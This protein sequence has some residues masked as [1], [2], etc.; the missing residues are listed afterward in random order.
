M[1]SLPSAEYLRECVDYDAETGALT[2]RA[3]PPAHFANSARHKA[4]VSQYAGKPA[5]ASKDGNGYL[6]GS[7]AGV[8]GIKAH[9]VIWKLVHG[10][11]PFHIDHANGDKT[12]NR[13]CNLRNVDQSENAKNKRL[14]RNNTSGHMGVRFSRDRRW[15][16]SI[17]ID[18]RDHHLGSYATKSEAILA[19][20]AAEARLGFHPNHGRAT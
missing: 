5:F 12:D 15:L 9:R 18:R 13:L 6:N 7:L 16:A 19:R 14:L 20:K 11:D 4:F 2:W 17:K 8:S 1:A 10:V 3:R